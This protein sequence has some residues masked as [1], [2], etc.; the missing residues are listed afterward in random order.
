MATVIQKFKMDV[1][2][3]TDISK[4]SLTNQYQVHISGIAGP[5]IRVIGKIK[6]RKIKK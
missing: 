4:L 2:N 3:R 6:M 5:V 1:L